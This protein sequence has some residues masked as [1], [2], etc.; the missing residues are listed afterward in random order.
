VQREIEANLLE[1][2]RKVR[3]FSP[4]SEEKTT[5][6]EKINDFAIDEHTS[7]MLFFIWGSIGCGVLL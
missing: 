7:Y 1:L 4:K 5:I 3:R 6:S 2:V